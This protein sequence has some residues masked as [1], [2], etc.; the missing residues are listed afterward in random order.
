MEV[1]RQKDSFGAHR[2]GASLTSESCLM[3]NYQDNIIGMLLHKQQRALFV[4]TRIGTGGYK[5]FLHLR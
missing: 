2:F 1:P 3:S 4:F 5:F